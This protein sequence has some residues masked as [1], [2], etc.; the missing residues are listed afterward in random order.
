MLDVAG[1]EVVWALRVEWRI[2]LAGMRPS[3]NIPSNRFSFV[4]VRIDLGEFAVVVSEFVFE[5][6]LVII[7]AAELLEDGL[8]VLIL[9]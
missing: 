5:A 6:P 9:G 4:A 8:G 7:G 2:M 3:V 1:D